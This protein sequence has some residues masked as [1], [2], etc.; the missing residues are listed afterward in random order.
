MPVEKMKM[1]KRTLCVYEGPRRLLKDEM[2][3][4]NDFQVRMQL[5]Q[6]QGETGAP[7]VG[8]GN[9]YVTDLDVRT[10]ERAEAFLNASEEEKGPWVP[11]QVTEKLLI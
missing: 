10:V 11:G 9:A 8:A 3:L 6:E 1:K 5:K 4:D 7:N 2:M